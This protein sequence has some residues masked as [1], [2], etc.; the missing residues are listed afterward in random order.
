MTAVQK[1]M[2]AKIFLILQ[3]DYVSQNQRI[4]MSI[5][6]FNA[7]YVAE[8]D[9]VLFRFNTS[10][11]Q[12]YRLW[13]TRVVVRNILALGAQA[14]VAVLAREHPP[15]QAKAVAEFKQQAKVEQAKFTTFVPATHFPMGADPILV[16]QARVSLKEKATALELVMPKGQV[17]TMNLTEDMM[18]Q[19]RLLL[20]TIAQ[21]AQWSLE[22]PTQ[23]APEPEQKLATDPVPGTN[24]K[25]LH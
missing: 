2:S 7:T 18:A 3:L 11:S 16:H 24:T 19:L 10:Q 21:R 14:S 6:Q 8:E 12:E 17:M 4:H 15:E 22:A 20:Q 1:R 23:V 5:T 25:V 9:R 13:L